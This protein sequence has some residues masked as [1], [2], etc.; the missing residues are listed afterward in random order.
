M[1]KKSIIILIIVVI[2]VAVIGVTIFFIN[3]HNNQSK[4]QSIYE[5]ISSGQD[6]ICIIEENENNKI[7]YAKKGEKYLTE[8]ISKQADSNEEAEHTAT[9]INED[10]MY[11]V[12]H[13]REEYYTYPRGD[14]KENIFLDE[15][16]QIVSENYQNG[17]EKVNGKNY[18]FE[19]YKGVFVYPNETI[20]E[21]EKQT[22]KFYFKGNELTYMKIEMGN[23][24]K[25][26]KIEIKFDV[27]DN[28]FEIPSNYAEV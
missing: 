27:D 1:K 23:K 4:L 2:I 26:R 10:K 22:T 5:K 7:I 11:L 16:N 14:N 25:I 15:M 9:I 19:E 12:L 13:N 21:E 20:S 18:N 28:I 6:Y 17:K 24:Q 3:K 8:T